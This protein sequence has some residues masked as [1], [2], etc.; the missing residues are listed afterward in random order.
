VE[1]GTLTWRALTTEDAP[2]LAR[3]NAVV[4]AVD[5]TGEH[6]SEQ[7]VRDEL[8]DESIDLGRD[9]LGALAPDGEVVAFARVH[10]SA[11]VGDLDR[12]DADGAVVPAARGRGLGR[13]LLEWAGERAAGLHRERHPNIP[14]AVC[15]DAHENNPSKQAL[16]RAVG[17][18]ATRWGYTMARSSDDPLPDVPP[19]R[20]GL[21]LA[22][23]AADRDVAVRGAHREAFADNWGYT[24]PDEQRWSRWYTGAKP[25]RPDVSWLVLDGDEVTA[26]LLT[27]CWEAD[28]AATG[29]REAFVGQLGV[30]PGWRRRGL[31]GLLLAAALQSYR[32]AGYGRS[33]L[34]VDAGN[35]TGALGLYERA[36]YAVTDTWVTWI[37]PLG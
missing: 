9:T 21:T 19:A 25:F 27:F 11:E 24:P 10:G 1:T 37:K 6:F 31:G 26:Y 12:V 36:G 3:A 30:R 8:E 15:V 4:E 20:P 2:A 17:Y 14:G 13:R 16:V 23:Y 7:D 35:A 33:A 5:C 22:P 34:A 28:A 18:A 32:S 29:V